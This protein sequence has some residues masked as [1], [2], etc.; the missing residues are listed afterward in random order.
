MAKALYGHLRGIPA[1]A[2]GCA[3]PG[4]PLE[5]A[6]L[7]ARIAELEAE[8]RGLRE[9]FAAPDDLAPLDE[10]LDAARVVPAPIG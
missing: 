5:L 6:R 10:L 9:H 2:A 7:R 3:D 4:H 1:P 8:I